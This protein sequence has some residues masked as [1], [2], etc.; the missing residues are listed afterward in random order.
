MNRGGPREN[1][2]QHQPGTLPLNPTIT[3]A[4]PKSPTPPKSTASSQ[5]P[6]A[7]RSNPEVDARIDAY[8]KENPKHWAHIQGMPR[9]RLER[10]VVL[11]EV[12]AIDRQQRVRE[13]VLARINKDPGLKQAYDHLVKDLPEDQRDTVIAQLARQQ[14]RVVARARGQGQEQT[15]GVQV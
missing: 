13:G 5:E 9:E 4:Q 7:Y 3:M 10:T 15:A 2:S 1:R 6:P 11:N 12:R 8:I 14:Q